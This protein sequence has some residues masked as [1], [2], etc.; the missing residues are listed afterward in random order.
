MTPSNDSKRTLSA[1]SL[2][3]SVAGLAILIVDALVSL[4]PGLV[5]G[6]AVMLVLLFFL[7]ASGDALLNKMVQV[8]P[9]MTNKKRIVTTAREIQR[10]V[11][12]YLGMITVINIGLG[13]VV[14]IAMY[15][16]GM[17]NPVLWGVMV[18]LLNYIP[19]IGV[20]TSM[21]VVAFV[22]LLTFDTP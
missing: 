2:M 19:Y 14:G 11:S 8:T 4:T 21:L 17:P 12:T 6:I 20:L 22:S 18:G 5:F 10:H 16:L 9:S 13:I 1:L 7:L 15:L 3:L